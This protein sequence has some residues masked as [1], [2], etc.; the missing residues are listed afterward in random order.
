MIGHALIDAIDESGYLSDS[1]EDVAGRLGSTALVSVVMTVA[2]LGGGSHQGSPSPL[3]RRAA[4]S[5][6]TTS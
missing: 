4:G 1:V 5:P 2:G 6:R 3:S